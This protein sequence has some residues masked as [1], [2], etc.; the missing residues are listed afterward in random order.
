M[1]PRARI[2]KTVMF[3][4]SIPLLVGA[5]IGGLEE[6]KRPL[7]VEFH[8]WLHPNRVVAANMTPLC[9]PY[10]A[11][12]ATFPLMCLVHPRFHIK[13]AGLL[14]YSAVLA[15]IGENEIRS[16]SLKPKIIYHF[17]RHSTHDLSYRA[18]QRHTFV[19]FQLAC[20]LQFFV[21]VLSLLS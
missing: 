8:G 12:T 14:A 15:D 3:S 13:L 17:E 2:L 18:R 11:V 9:K 20:F 7:G 10:A 4:G 21:Q 5:I 16:K 1:D 19:Y 6:A